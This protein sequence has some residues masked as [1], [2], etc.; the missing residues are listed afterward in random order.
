MI[1]HV[2]KNKKTGNLQDSLAI[3]TILQSHLSQSALQYKPYSLISTHTHTHIYAGFWSRH[4]I[5]SVT[6]SSRERS[7]FNEGKHPVN[8]RAE[9]SSLP[10]GYLLSDLKWEGQICLG[11]INKNA[12]KCC[13]EFIPVFL[14]SLTNMFSLLPHFPQA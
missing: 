6:H 8:S 1:L 3:V 5:C 9:I 14:L 4:S 2:S 7:C 12:A 11:H 10:S 13:M